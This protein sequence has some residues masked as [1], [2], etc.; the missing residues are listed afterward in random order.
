MID[1]DVYFGELGTDRIHVTHNTLQARDITITNE[2]LLFHT[3]NMNM[4]DPPNLAIKE[5]TRGGSCGACFRGPWLVMRQSRTHSPSHLTAAE[6]LHTSDEED[7]LYDDDGKTVEC[8]RDISM[9][10]VRSAADFFTT[11]YR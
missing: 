9:R 4:D 5:F 2:N 11:S 6:P 8:Y 1:Y 10:D 3:K 7:D